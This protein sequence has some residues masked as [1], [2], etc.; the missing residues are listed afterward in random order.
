MSTSSS[1]RSTSVKRGL[2]LTCYVDGRKRFRAV[3]LRDEPQA[4]GSAGVPPMVAPAGRRR[5]AKIGVEDG[6]AR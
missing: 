2:V 3:P 4:D 5:S 1:P 6:P